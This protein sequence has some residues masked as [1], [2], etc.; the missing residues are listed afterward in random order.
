[1]ERTP[2]LVEIHY[3]LWAVLAVPIGFAGV[4]FLFGLLLVEG[5]ILLGIAGFCIGYVAKLSQRARLAW[6]LGLVV[7]TALLAGAAYY[8]PRWPE[9]IAV[10]L[11]LLNLYSLVVLLVYRS[12]WTSAA[13]PQPA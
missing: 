9:L 13:E 2:A 7:H 4:F 3:A 6:L 11:A 12:A 1:M 10:P 5:T 8:V